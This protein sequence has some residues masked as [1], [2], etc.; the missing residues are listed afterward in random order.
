MGTQ[1]GEIETLPATNYPADGSLP[2]KGE[3]CPRCGQPVPEEAEKCPSCGRRLA[4]TWQ[5]RQLVLT[6]TLAAV[7]SLFA[8]TTLVASRYHGMERTLG[9]GHPG[10]AVEAFRTALVYS[11]DN[12][13]YQM[14]VAQALSDTGRLQ[15]AR[16]YLLN[17]WQGEPGNG[18]VNLALARVS[19]RLGSAADAERYYHNAVYGS[20]ESDAVRARENARLELANYLL[21]RGAKQAA[22]ADLIALAAGL[23]SQSDLHTRVGQL[24]LRIDSYQ[25]AAGE[26][27]LALRINPKD[28]DALAGAGQASFDEGDYA[29]A[30]RYLTR[31]VSLRPDDEE[32]HELLQVST[33]VL[34]NDPYARGISNAERVRRTLR[35]FDHAATRFRSCVLTPEGPPPSDEMQQLDARLDKQQ[36]TVSSA[37]LRRDP[38]LM[39]ATIDLAFDLEQAA[40]RRC[41]QGDAFD[42]AVALIRRATREARP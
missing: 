35:I 8:V 23:S 37:R 14:S 5:R 36:A 15:E 34:E 17:L 38:D 27:D 31:A 41:G 32:S 30:R 4:N 18:S 2:P 21:S 20:W 29:A 6:L 33:L 25:R 13:L 11:G 40:D 10:E 39:E 28:A 16:V 12:F 42:Q 7:V 26:F 19:V 24:F 22:E 1:P 9:A 3:V